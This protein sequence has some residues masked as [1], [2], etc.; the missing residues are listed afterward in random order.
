MDA[1]MCVREDIC[2]KH[3][4]S[5]GLL[6]IS[7]GGQG[8]SPSNEHCHQEQ[9]NCYR[10]KVCAPEIHMLRP[11]CLC[12]GIRSWGFWKV[13][14]QESRDFMDGISALIKEIS[15]NLLPPFVT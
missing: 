15:E 1:F 11:N 2:R 12:D 5:T 10:P 6:G 8:C 4:C 14:G 9:G 13:L 3:E 7:Y